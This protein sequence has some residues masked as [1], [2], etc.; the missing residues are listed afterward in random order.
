M[1]NV[2]CGLMRA[3]DHAMYQVKNAGRGHYAFFHA[4]SDLLPAIVTER[5]HG[6]FI[7]ELAGCKNEIG[8]IYGN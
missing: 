8:V 3:A 2:T 6:A 4:E 7:R 1:V 5:R